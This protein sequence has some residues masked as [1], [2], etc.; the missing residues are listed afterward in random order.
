M[1]LPS[2]IISALVGTGG[3]AGIVYAIIEYRKTR[4]KTK[5]IDEDTALSRLSADYERKEQEA[6]KAWRIANWFRSQYP[7][8]WAAYMRLPGAEKERFPP[9]PPPELDESS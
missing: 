3:T 8:L 7:L 1:E 4:H 6:A 2:E 9:A 5:Q